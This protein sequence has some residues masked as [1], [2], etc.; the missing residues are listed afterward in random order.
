M[1]GNSLTAMIMKN[2]PYLPDK[3]G[4]DGSSPSAPTSEKQV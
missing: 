3:A 4:V 1:A 2:T